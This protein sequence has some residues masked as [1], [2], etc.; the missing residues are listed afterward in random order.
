MVITL[1]SR[2]KL[3]NIRVILNIGAKVSVITLN[4]VLR[5][6]IPITY[7]FKIALRTIIK[8][9]SRFIRFI[10]NITVIV[11]N[12]IIKTRFYIINYFRIKVI[13]SF[14]FIRK[15]RVIF[16]YSRNKK[17]K[18]V[19]TLLYNPRTRNIISIKTNI[20]TEKA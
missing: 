20:K 12:T 19:F 9:K 4:T 16:T 8:N 1:I 18:P 7:S 15:A 6:E 5:F 3:T 11:G 17:D 2:G 14:L 13:L 10:N